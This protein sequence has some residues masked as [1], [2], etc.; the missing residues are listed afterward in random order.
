MNTTV[1]KLEDVSLYVTKSEKSI[2]I[3]DVKQEKIATIW[4]HLVTEYPDYEVFFSFNSERMGSNQ[5]IPTEFLAEINAQ[6][7][8]DA[9]NFSLSSKD[10][11]SDHESELE[12]NLLSE[13]EFAEFA[14]F[15]DYYNPDFFWT[16][17][18][19]Q[20]CQDI[21]QIHILKTYG[22]L[23]GYAMTLISDQNFAEIFTIK[24]NNKLEFKALLSTTCKTAFASG[25]TGILY[26]IEKASPA[27]HQQ[28]AKGLGFKET[29]F[30]KG[31]RAVTN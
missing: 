23:S 14:K 26:M 29:G 18:R 10:N 8:D 28:M 6:L 25:K 15:H 27:S 3:N 2:Q 7:V 24:S 30:Y 5:E 16:S 17:K 9:L 13:A 21:W 11:V 12:I 20:E 4:E 1:V 22:H 19:I 31:F